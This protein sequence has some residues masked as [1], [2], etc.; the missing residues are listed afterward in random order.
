MV[1]TQVSSTQRGILPNISWH[2]FEIM[3]AEMGNNR[4]TRLTYDQGTLEIMTP[5]MP[6]EYNNRLL[7]HLVFTLAEELN[8]NIKSIGSTTCKRPDLL[9]GVEPDSAFYIQ[10]EPLMRQKQNLDLT[11][12]PPPD[13]V[14]EVDYTSASVD[15]LSIYLALGVPEVWR[16]DEPVMQ[17]YCLQ[18]GTYI[19][20]DV[21]PSFF[22]LPLTTE[23]PRF[24]QES[25]NNG[26]I[27][28]IRS[29]RAWVRQ[30]Q[31]N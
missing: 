4:T 8:L 12:D 30:Q 17:I 20:C 24:L 25:L 16:Y 23:I 11:Q 18:E 7:E 3:L 21:S 29:F 27:P 2:T 10:N 31:K 9:R 15:R 26:E 14:I 22:N 5:L 13:L 1:T 19:P 6:H 28:M